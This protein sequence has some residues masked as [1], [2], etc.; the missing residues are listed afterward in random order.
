[1]TI[2]VNEIFYTLQGEGALT[3]IPSVFVRLSGCPLRCKW[4]DTKYAWPSDCGDDYTI[5]QIID[6]V[7]RYE[8]DFV[9]ITGGEPMTNPLLLN[10]CQA[11]NACNKHITIETSGINYLFDLPIDMMSISPK[12]TNA[13]E[14]DCD[15]YEKYLVPDVLKRLIEDY[16]YQLK[17][18]ISAESDID[19]VQEILKKL[20]PTDM[21][22]TMLMPAAADRDEYLKNATMVAELCKKYGYRFSP[23]IQAILWDSRAGM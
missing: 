6:A 11:L 10:L 15:E 14:S 7:V 5:E 9:V 8:T 17:F 22:V 2:K 19:E 23:R 3:G 12:L 21:A 4:C 13:V 1:M 18:V 16:P 20:P